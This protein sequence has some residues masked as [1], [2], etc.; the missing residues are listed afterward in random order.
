VVSIDAISTRESIWH[1]STY[2][3]TVAI[4]GRLESPAGKACWTQ[5]TQGMS[6]NYGYSGSIENYQETLN[7]ALDAA[8][9]N[10]V[11]LQGFKDGLCKC[12]D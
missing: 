1:R 2:D 11:R 8:S 12:P 4:T 3:A 9:G 10:L 7:S 5:T 6:S